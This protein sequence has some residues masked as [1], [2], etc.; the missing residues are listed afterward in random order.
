VNTTTTADTGLPGHREAMG[1]AATEYER[2]LD[3]LRRFGPDDWAQPTDCTLWDVRAVVA[4]NL[5]NMEANASLREMTHQM[6]T[7]I[8]R[9]KASGAAMI[10]E[11]TA[12]QVE[13]RATLTPAELRGQIEAIV[14]RALRGRRRLPALPRKVVRIKTPVGP[15]SLGYLND[16]IYTR[17]V[18]MH[19]V[20]LTQATS[21]D[22][23]LTAG[24]DGRLVAGV[25]GDWATRH[26]QAFELVLDGPAGGAFRRGD[27]GEKL[28]LDAVEFCR[29]VSGRNTASVRGLLAT[30]V[31]F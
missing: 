18:W 25:V 8:G 23:V 22:M 6:R 9:A 27:S 14:P 16:T 28:Q 21:Q 11:M 5:A 12:L 13:E 29:I 20:D 31:L 4:H 15:V 10:D 19:R 3:L 2:F 1:L 30:E 24:H 7:A 17:D 26:G